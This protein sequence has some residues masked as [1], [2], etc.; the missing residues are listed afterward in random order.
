MLH[1]K[2]NKK[3]SKKVKSGKSRKSSYNSSAYLIEQPDA[4]IQREL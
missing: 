4:A 1:R 3:K 2:N